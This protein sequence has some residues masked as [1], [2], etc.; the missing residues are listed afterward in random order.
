MKKFLNIKSKYNIFNM[1]IA[2]LTF[3]LISGYFLDKSTYGDYGRDISFNY[4]ESIAGQGFAIMIVFYY[5]QK[6]VALL[7]NYF[8]KK[9]WSW[10]TS[11]LF[12]IL[13]IMGLLF[14]IGI[15]P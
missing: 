11:Y 3:C 2:P 4:I 5:P 9:E 13:P 7:F 10:A 14:T 15:I 1:L 6:I 8:T 12:W